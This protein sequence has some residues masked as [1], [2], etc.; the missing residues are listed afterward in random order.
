MYFKNP[1]ESSHL[2]TAAKFN[3]PCPAPPRLLLLHS[4][5]TT[6]TTTTTTNTTTTSFP[7]MEFY[8]ETLENKMERRTRKKDRA[9]MYNNK[10]GNR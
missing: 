9:H 8:L 1:T 10:E 4:T 2:M 6:N 7:L 3:P 5:A